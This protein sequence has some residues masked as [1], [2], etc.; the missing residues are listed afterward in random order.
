MATVTQGSTTTLFVSNVLNGGAARGGT[1]STTRPSCGSAEHRSG[2]PK[3]QSE[4]V[5]ADNI[6]WRDDKAA[7]A[8]GPTGV[9]L[10]SNGT[11]YVADTLENRIIAIPER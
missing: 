8:I 5:V 6:P 7:L 2:M 10:A 3:V 9:A 4:T 11:L 1:R